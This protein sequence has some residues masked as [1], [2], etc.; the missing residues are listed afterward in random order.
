MLG[1]RTV[2]LATLFFLLVGFAFTSTSALSYW[3]EVTVSYDISLVTIGEPVELIIDDLNQNK[4]VMYLVP[5]GY[6]FTTDETDQ[7][8]LEYEISVSK[9]LLNAVDLHMMIKDILIDGNSTYSHF[10]DITILGIS[11]EVV[12]DLYN[13]IILVTI[14]IR[15]IEPIDLDEAIKR[16][17]DFS[18]V[19]TEDSV[20]AYED[21]KG[22]DIQ[23]TLSLELTTKPEFNDQ[24]EPE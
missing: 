6:V 14:E 3:R 8:I 21:L 17:L 13:S 24:V 9:E 10:V 7:I 12:L 2:R 19:N 15:L 4:D 16:N 18:L 23:F 11:D 20:Q 5:A 22:K 1:G